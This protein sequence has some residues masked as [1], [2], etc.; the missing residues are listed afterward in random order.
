MPDVEHLS[1]KSS[2][3]PAL[4]RC[5]AEVTCVSEAGVLQKSKDQENTNIDVN[6]E[7]YKALAE[8]EAARN[9]NGKAGNDDQVADSVSDVSAHH[10]L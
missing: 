5:S 2:I 7:I 9:N 3:V 6:P 1:C 10:K 8:A 4:C